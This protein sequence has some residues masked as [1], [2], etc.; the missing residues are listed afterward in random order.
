MVL[1]ALGLTLRSESSRATI[2]ELSPDGSDVIG[3]DAT[4]AT[5]YEDTLLDV[6][7]RYSLGYDEII[8]ANPGVMCPEQTTMTGGQG[9]NRI[10][11]LNT[12][13]YGVL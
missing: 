1:A 3:S 8:R 9:G 12:K 13:I 6:A 5:H 11:R 2:F 10:D 7:R 4:I